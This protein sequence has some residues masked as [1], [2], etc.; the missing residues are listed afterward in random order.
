MF[1]KTMPLHQLVIYILVFRFQQLHNFIVN[2]FC[3][4]H[5][6]ESMGLLHYM[7]CFLYPYMFIL[8]IQLESVIAYEP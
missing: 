8:S 2:E 6:H 3:F 1:V 5:M 4:R 7:K